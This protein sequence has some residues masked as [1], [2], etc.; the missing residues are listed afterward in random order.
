M[1]LYN[2]QVEQRS[3]PKG[4]KHNFYI[5]GPISDDINEFVDMITIMDIAE[6][7]DE[8]HLFI[9][10]PGGS[11]DTTLSILHAMIRCKATIMTHADGLVASAGTLLFL[12]GHNY[13]VYPYATFMAH[14][15]SSGSIGKINENLKNVMSTASLIRKICNDLYYPF[16]SLE[17]INEILEGKDY[18][19]DADEIV[20]RINKAEKFLREEH[21]S[22]TEDE[23]ETEDDPGLVRIIEDPVYLNEVGKIIHEDENFVD[24]ELDNSVV[25]TV[26]KDKIEYVK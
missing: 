23:D 15:G 18:Y 17:E 8:I 7:H 3:F 24:I 26:E 2:N 4:A 21:E 9:N 16:F 12:A 10:T 6:E 19:C 1:L 20:D 13:C 5:Y 14:D 22:K 25:V 11:L